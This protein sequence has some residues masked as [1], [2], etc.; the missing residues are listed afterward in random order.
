MLNSEEM[1]R[2]VSSRNSNAI[3]NVNSKLPKKDSINSGSFRFD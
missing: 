2:I 3:S 1:M